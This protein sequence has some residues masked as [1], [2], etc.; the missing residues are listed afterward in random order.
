M[1]QRESAL[2]GKLTVIPNGIFAPDAARLVPA[3]ETRDALGIPRLSLL[4]VCVARL[5]PEKDIGSLIKAMGAV[6]DQV[7]GVRCVIAGDGPERR[8]LEGQIR[9]VPWA[10][11]ITLLGFRQDA[12]SLIRAADIFVLPS[13]AEPFGLV[14]L[15]AMALGKPVVSI[16][17]GGPLEIVKNGETGLLVPPGDPPAL[18]GAIIEFLSDPKFRRKA[19]ENG[20]SSFQT[21]FTAQAMA[22]ATLRVYGQALSA[23]SVIMPMMEE[24]KCESC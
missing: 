15:E 11:Q 10:R 14:L 4:V 19:G 20:C 2:A 21:D 24:S 9:N 6:A 12:I 3:M 1:I 18:A 5:A 7:S 23:R 17:A 13:R 22:S 8:A 16:A